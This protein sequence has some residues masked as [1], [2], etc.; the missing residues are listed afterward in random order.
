MTSVRIGTPLVITANGEHG[1][2]YYAR[3]LSDTI[4]TIGDKTPA[5]VRLQVQAFKA[6]IEHAAMNYVRQAVRSDRMACARDL[7]KAGML[8]AAE[9]LRTRP[10]K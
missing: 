10:V 9:F 3:R 5:P 7:E 8:E 1:S 4:I 2:K 6:A